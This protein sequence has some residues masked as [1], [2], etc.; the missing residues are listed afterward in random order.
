[1]PRRQIRAILITC[2]V[3]AAL[4][5]G[6]FFLRASW[7]PFSGNDL[8][9]RAEVERIGQFKF[10]PGAT[11]I[12]TSYVGM[13]DPTLQVRFKLPA[14]DLD[15]F[16]QSASLP[17]PLS[18]SAIPHDIGNPGPTQPWWNPRRPAVFQAGE[19]TTQAGSS[20]RE[21]HRAVLIDQSD[22]EQFV[23]WLVAYHPLVASTPPA[24]A[25]QP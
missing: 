11:E 23:V 19:L 1:M 17:R 8:Q 25:P 9:S 16:M 12:A 22:P 5:V 18:S 21:L 3:P 14:R 13:Q 7:I 4:T 20:R 10:P 6:W 2:A 24:T 15:Q